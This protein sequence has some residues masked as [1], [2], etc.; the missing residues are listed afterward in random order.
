MPRLYFDELLLQVL[1][2][3]P[4]KEALIE[5]IGGQRSPCAGY[6][7]LKWLKEADDL[8]VGRRIST[9]CYVEQSVPAAIYLALEFMTTRKQ[10]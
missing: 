7:F 2:D 1:D 8:V 6:P 3:K 9:E 4:L 5:Q 10:A